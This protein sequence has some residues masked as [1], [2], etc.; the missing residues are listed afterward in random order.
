[1]VNEENWGFIDLDEHPDFIT[2]E[3]NWDV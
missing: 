1:M 2:S 3:E